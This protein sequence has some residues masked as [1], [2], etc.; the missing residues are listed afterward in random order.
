MA[1]DALMRVCLPGSSFICVLV[2]LSPSI[3]MCVCLS[4]FVG[5]WQ[6]YLNPIR[7]KKL[8]A[9]KDTMVIFSIIEMLVPVNQASTTQHKSGRIG[10]CLGLE[11]CVCVYM[12]VCMYE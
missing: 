3:Y 5:G 9:A 6:S 10:A 1:P 12:Y 7:N 4:M 2:R 11:R 8:L